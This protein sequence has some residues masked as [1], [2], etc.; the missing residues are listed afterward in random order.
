MNI[1]T[2]VEELVQWARAGLA[3]P[4]DTR[5]RLVNART[6]LSKTLFEIEEISPRGRRRIVAKIANSSRGGETFAVIDKLWQAGFRPPSEFTVCQP[7]AW[8]PEQGMLLVER[9]P[10][11]MLMDLI[12]GRAPETPA[13][14]GAAAR[15]L[16]TLHASGVEAKP[17]NGAIPFLERCERELCQSLQKQSSRISR[18]ARRLCESF[19]ES[20]PL[21]PSHGDFHPMNIFVDDGRITLIDLDT[22]SMRERAA[23]V[24]YFVAQTMIMG[25]MTFGDFDSTAGVRSAF[26]DSYWAFSK[27]EPDAARMRT[28]T[29]YAFLQSLHYEHCVL[30]TR[31]SRIIEPWLAQAEDCC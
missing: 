24:A 26:V 14:V 13:K 4:A 5:W 15:W 9:A 18:I 6:K 20:H 29:A 1:T 3:P 19:R 2:S 23:D 31:N 25:W 27:H 17:W 10:G 11:L 30:R 28:H 21:V 8:L 22:F 12:R 16:A 7:L